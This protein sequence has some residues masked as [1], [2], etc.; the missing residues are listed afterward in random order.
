MMLALLHSNANG[1][2]RTER[3]GDTERGYQKPAV[4]QKNTDDAGLDIFHFLHASVS[5][6][7]E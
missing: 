4:Q 3:Y 7:V 1:Q 5:S 2:L 6:L